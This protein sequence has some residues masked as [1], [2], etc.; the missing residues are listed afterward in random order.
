MTVHLL[1]SHPL[2]K[3]PLYCPIE[4]RYWWCVGNGPVRREYFQFDPL[5]DRGEKSLKWSITVFSIQ[6]LDHEYSFHG[7]YFDVGWSLHLYETI[8]FAYQYQFHFV[9]TH[10]KLY[11]CY[12]RYSHHNDCKENETHGIYSNKYMQIYINLIN[13][14]YI[15]T[16]YYYKK[17]ILSSSLIKPREKFFMFAFFFQVVSCVCMFFL[18]MSSRMQ[19]FFANTTIQ[20]LTKLFSWQKNI[21]LIH[22]AK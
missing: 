3:H 14:Q 7:I 8:K 1:N 5:T 13:W 18:S 12:P 22:T 11:L 21:P 20:M 16:Y 4:T 10:Q 17:S 15:A 9:R 2:S 6:D 19:F